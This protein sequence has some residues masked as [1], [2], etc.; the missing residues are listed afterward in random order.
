MSRL[1]ASRYDDKF[2]MLPKAIVTL[3]GMLPG[4]NPSVILVYMALRDRAANNSD[5]KCWPTFYDLEFE[6]GISAKTISRSV[7][8]LAKYGLIDIL[9]RNSSRNYTYHVHE[10]LT[11]AEFAVKYPDV[12]KEWER[13]EAEL[14]ARKE[15]DKLRL[16][17][18]QDKITC[19]TG[20]IYM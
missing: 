12:F 9:T 5:R 16:K 7:N 10:P 13:K 19:S 18:A 1:D 3:Y 14:N 20:Q 6:L 15:A 11:V 2:Y 4:F 8:T 17:Q